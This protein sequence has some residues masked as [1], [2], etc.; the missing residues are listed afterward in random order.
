MSRPLQVFIGYD[1]HS[2][3]AYHVLAHSIMRR[4]SR[5]VSVT[6]LYQPQ[7]RAM[8]AYTRE[9]GATESTEFSI[10]RFLAPW[11]GGFDGVSIF[12]DNDMLC[13]GDI[14]ELEEIAYA[15]PYQDVFCVQHDYAPKPDPKFL[16]RYQAVYPRKNWSSVMVFNGHRSPVRSLRPEYVNAA[17]PSD[18]H[19]FAWAGSI[20]ALPPEWNHLVGEYD[21][22]PNAKIVHYTLGGPWFAG[23]EKVE[24]A[25]EWY[26]EFDSAIHASQGTCILSLHNSNEPSTI[27]LISTGISER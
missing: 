4:A 2:A 5:P 12:L 6:P 22:N 20:G 11:L 10:T 23:C 1:P 3:V 15:D 16:G 9:R 25:K 24:Y 13:L 7:L 27:P 19:Q 14:C 8:G 21:K 26:A 18:L 17:N